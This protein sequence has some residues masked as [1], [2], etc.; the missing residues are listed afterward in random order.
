MFEKYAEQ[1]HDDRGYTEQDGRIGRRRQVYTA[2]KYV[3]IDCIT[4]YAQ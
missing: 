3:L 4:G 1:R 2:D